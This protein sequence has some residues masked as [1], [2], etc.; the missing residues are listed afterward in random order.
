MSPDKTAPNY[1]SQRVTVLS[2]SPLAAARPTRKA[3]YGELL[4]VTA[5]TTAFALIVALVVYYLIATFV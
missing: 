4:F 1:G 2:S 5:T 3:Q